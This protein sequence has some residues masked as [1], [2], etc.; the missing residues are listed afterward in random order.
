MSDSKTKALMQKPNQQLKAKKVHS[1]EDKSEFN[2]L[3]VAGEGVSK[4]ALAAKL[5]GYLQSRN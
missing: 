2:F 1:C 3:D 4:S 5:S